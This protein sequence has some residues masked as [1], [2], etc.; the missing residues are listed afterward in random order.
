MLK[1][2]HFARI[3]KPLRQDDLEQLGISTERLII[4]AIDAGDTE[5]AKAL[6]RYVLD[7]RK[8]LHDM[9][10]DTY[11][12]FLTRIGAAMGEAAVGQILRDSA[13]DGLKRTWKAFLKMTV[14]ERVQMC[15]QMMRSHAFSAEA[16]GSGV[17][18]VED[19]EKYTLSMNPC[20]SGGRMRRGDPASGTPS[21]LGPPYNF[22]VAERAYDWTWNTPGVP[23]YC[24]HCAINEILP[25]D[26]GG[27][28][29]WVTAFDTDASKPC[30]WLFYK[31]AVAIPLRFYE[32][33]G[34]SKP[35]AGEGQY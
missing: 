3:R 16:D 28:P 11:W 8:P 29:L 10:C 35:P 15:A 7:E 20:G 30:A 18:V 22:A 17:T 32:R 31:K 25:M 5:R 2:E 19:E 13:L 6:V 21:R 1:L 12:D 34:R 14:L 4:E 23:Y 33:V 27:H 24:G 9:Q 26:W